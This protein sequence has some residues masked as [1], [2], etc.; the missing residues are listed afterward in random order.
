[1]HEKNLRH[2]MHE[3]SEER[4]K[5]VEQILKKEAI[6]YHPSPAYA[7]FLRQHYPMI[8]LAL[9]GRREE[10]EKR[11]KEINEIFAGLR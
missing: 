11:Q 6:A 3:K 9:T 5:L 7:A 10:V 2:L 8:Y 1:M 4:Q